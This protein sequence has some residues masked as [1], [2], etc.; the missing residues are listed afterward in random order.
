MS[1]VKPLAVGE[2][3]GAHGIKGGVWVRPFGDVPGRAHALRD[4][5]LMRGDELAPAR[6]ASVR[7]V[8]RRWT[9]TFEGITSRTEAEGL[10]GWLIGVTERAAPPLPEGTFYVHDLVGRE[11]ATEDG[12]FLGVVT[13]VMHTGGN[14]VYVI[15]G[16]EGELLFPALKEL[17]LECAPGART[18][19]VRL[20]PGLL[21]ACL[22]R[23]A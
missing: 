9:V 4:V 23:R 7:V 3:M 1:G 18:M 12:A 15:D 8:E 21:E 2:I 20:L 22:T 6:V 19:R 14:D 16:P 11:V 13:D 10:S 5:V 17:V